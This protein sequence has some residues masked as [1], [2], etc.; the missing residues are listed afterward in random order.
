MPWS[1]KVSKCMAPHRTA[2]AK[3]LPRSCSANY[4]TH[5]HTAMRTVSRQ[6]PN[7]GRQHNALLASSCQHQRLAAAI[8]RAAWRC[9]RNRCVGMRGSG[10]VN[11]AGGAG[12]TLTVRRPF[13]RLREKMT[14]PGTSANSVWS[15]PCND[16]RRQSHN[17]SVTQLAFEQRLILVPTCFARN[18]RSK[19]TTRVAQ[20]RSIHDVL[21]LRCAGS[22]KLQGSPGRRWCQGGILCRAGAR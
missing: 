22:N 11:V 7:A 13:K 9:A 18:I 6:H 10:G 17:P 16:E 21:N 15:R 14:W 8:A 4:F 19:A 1:Q 12:S 20:Q 2:R 5:I 3:I